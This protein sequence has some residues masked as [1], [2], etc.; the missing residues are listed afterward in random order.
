MNTIS[1]LKLFLPKVASG[2]SP[3]PFHSCGLAN[4][5]KKTQFPPRP[6]INEDEIEEVFIKGGYVQQQIQ[7][8]TIVLT[9]A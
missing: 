6:K 1:K 5:M 7:F 8:A 3:K 2:C 9:F 4:A